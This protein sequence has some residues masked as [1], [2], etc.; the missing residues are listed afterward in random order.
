M[1]VRPGTTGIE[2]DRTAVPQAGCP[3]DGPADRWRQRDLNHLA[4]LAAHAQHPVAV[5]FAEVGDVGA[6]G[7]EDRKP[8]RSSMATSAKSDGFGDSDRR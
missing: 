4:A 2:Q 8:S 6:G 3:V 7:F 1:T 5:F